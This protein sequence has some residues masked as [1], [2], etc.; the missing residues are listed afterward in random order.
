MAATVQQYA[1]TLQ[2]LPIDLP[3]QTLNALDLEGKT[4]LTHAI[5]ARNRAMTTWLLQHCADPD[6]TADN[7]P[8]YRPV[9]AAV[10]AKD[11]FFLQQLLDAGTSIHVKD[12]VQDTPLNKALQQQHAEHFY[13]LILYGANLDARH[14]RFRFGYSGPSTVRQ[15]IQDFPEGTS[16][17]LLR[18]A[19]KKALAARRRLVVMTLAAR[20]APKL[21]PDVLQLICTFSGVMDHLKNDPSKPF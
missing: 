15:V 3:Q 8:H 16:G 7:R 11:I 10:N 17:A 1:E 19:V 4:P 5:E 2:L 20:A 9:F 13:L 14:A 6:F 21:V 18:D 12:Y